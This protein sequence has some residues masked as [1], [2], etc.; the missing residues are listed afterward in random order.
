MLPCAV[1]PSPLQRSKP[2]PLFLLQR[3]PHKLQ[4]HKLQPQ[5]LRRCLNRNRSFPRQ[6]RQ[7][8]TLKSRLLLPKA[9]LILLKR[10]K[11]LKRL[12]PQSR[13]R[14]QPG[15]WWLCVVTTDLARRKPN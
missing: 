3:Q 13:P 7:L 5:M 10:P 2:Q 9:A 6:A 4:P 14:N 11:Q 12:L 15:R 1:K 8:R